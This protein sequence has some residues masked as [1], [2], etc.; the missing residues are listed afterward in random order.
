MVVRDAWPVAVAAVAGVTVGMAVVGRMV[1]GVAASWRR[2]AFLARAQ[3]GRVRELCA[4]RDRY[5]HA[6]VALTDVLVAL[7]PAPVP[8]DLR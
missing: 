4:E 2:E 8:H 5:G 1:R 6:S 3:V 7:E